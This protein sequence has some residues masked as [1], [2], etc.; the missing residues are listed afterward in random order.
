[1]KTPDSI[2]RPRELTVADVRANYDTL[3]S[4]SVPAPFGTR[5]KDVCDANAFIK[6]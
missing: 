5:N 3:M 6:R 1:M 2:T 4:G